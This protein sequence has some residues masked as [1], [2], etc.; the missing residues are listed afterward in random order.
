MR[1]SIIS[2]AAATAVA[3]AG[4]GSAADLEAWK[5]RSIY[6]VMIDRFARTDGS[7][8]VA[9]DDLSVF[10]GGTWKGLTNNL[11]YIQGEHALESTPFGK[12]A[13]DLTSVWYRHGLHCRPNQ[14]HCQEP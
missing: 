8:D 4:L 7:T 14:P 1:T 2:A 13:R 11:D 5:S 10:C 12:P 9:C 3:F 6:Q